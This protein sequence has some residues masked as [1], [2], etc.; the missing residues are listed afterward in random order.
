MS[1]AEELLSQL[2]TLGVQLRLEGE[3]L[4]LNAPKG[5]LTPELQSQLKGSKAEIV[6]L[7]HSRQ[8]S[9]GASSVISIP[10]VMR[11]PR[12]PISL[13][14]QRLWFLQ[15]IE[16]QSAAYNMVVFLRLAGNLQENVL[17]RSLFDIVQRHEDLRTVFGQEEGT[18]FSRLIDGTQWQL[19]RP[20]FEL[21]NGERLEEA[22]FR[23]SEDRASDLFDLEVGPLFRAFL[24]PVADEEY[25]VVLAMHHIIADGWSI[26]VIV[27]E[28]AENYQAYCLNQLPRLPDLPIQ[29]FDYA[30]WQRTWL[31]R[32][33]LDRQMP[34][35]RKQLEGAPGLSIFPPDHPR[36]N[37]GTARGK[38]CRFT[39]SAALR[40]QI[41]SFSRGHDATLFMTLLSAF[42]LMLARYSGQR[43]VVVGSPVANRGRAELS[44]LV[45]FFVN[46]LVLR[47]QVDE[48]I[49]FQELLNRVRETTLGAFEHQEMPFDQLVRELQTDR[50]VDYAPI[51]QT[52][53]TL[54]NFPLE[55]LKLPGVTVSPLE[56]D[57]SI[58]RF[59][60]TFEVY[61][62]R[63][64]LLVVIEYRA[65][66]YDE[67]TILQLQQSY[68]HILQ[69]VVDAPSQSVDQVPLLPP[70]AREKLLWLGAI[71]SHAPTP[72]LLVEQL[73]RFSNETPDKVAVRAGIDGLTYAELNHRA[74]ALAS[75][76]I[77][78]GAG[79]GSLVPV[80][81]HRSTN[82][83]TA[84][85]AVLKTGAAY[86]PL[87]PIYPAQR[88]ASIL[89]DVKPS[90]LISEPTLLPLL[91]GQRSHAILL[92]ETWSGESTIDEFEPAF[93]DVESHAD[94]LAYVI[95]TSGS[96]GRPKG[97]EITHG[98][99]AN[100]LESMRNSPGLNQS[101]RLL[102]VTTVSFDI[103]GLE[104]FLPL[105]VGG[106]VVIALAPGDLP[107][108]LD[109]LERAAPTVM[110]AT[111]AL[112]QMLVSSGWNGNPNLTAL[113]G[114]EA[115]TPQLAHSLLPRVKELWNMYGPTETAACRSEG[116]FATLPSSF[117]IRNENRR[118]W[119]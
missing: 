90:V 82:L 67:K 107:A 20:S 8:D 61:P 91:G 118:P 66:L 15:Q 7:L 70:S 106:E 62:Y 97:V 34:Y 100:F 85:L 84:L 94:D 52:M 112:W 78:A 93:R 14:Q 31:E 24:L 116:R 47:V 3:T 59:D 103:A 13:A 92:D 41:E 68:A 46:N 48:G 53:F 64:E 38:R 58:A 12:M 105:Y 28:L 79:R 101:D 44:D 25:L 75:T 11:Q 89:E 9:G 45:G 39:L 83:L 5:A 65:D 72:S 1:H 18:P 36:R 63:N 56:V 10:R 102:A 73:V 26:G 40:A 57:G 77:Q 114:G 87:D 42:Q 99:L 23:F 22:A 29:Y 81:L 113:C 104:L 111:P 49:S 80:C 21:R 50:S 27:R 54:Q 119:A 6:A 16:P 19:E 110:Q 115:L 96:T 17:E 4:R 32:G 71:Q 51:F 55:D 109:D 60:L 2:R 86:V 76:L 74:N 69:S 33:V 108:L 30:E 88:I 98:S 43:D 117:W 37:D 35:W 95:F